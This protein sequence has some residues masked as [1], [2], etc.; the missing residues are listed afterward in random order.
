MLRLAGL[1]VLGAGVIL[2]TADSPFTDHQSQSPG[3]VH[4]ITVDDLPRPYATSAAN[5]QAVLVPRPDGMLPQAP[6]GFTVD[7][8]VSG[9]QGPRVM[10]TAPNGDV[11]V[12][13]SGFGRIRVVRAG[14]GSEPPS[15]QTFLSGL[16][17]PYGIAFYPPG[18]DPR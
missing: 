12:A 8:Y 11:F 18:P 3:R 1:L 9:L 6:V 5:N 15:V 2:Q 13:E 16:Q 7:L 14:E 17:Q 4:R 10:R